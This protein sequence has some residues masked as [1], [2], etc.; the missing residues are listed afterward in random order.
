MY[1]SSIKMTA[2]EKWNIDK[3]KIECAK[4]NGYNIIVVWENDYYKDSKEFIK[5]CIKFINEN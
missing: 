2:E 3:N 1:N 5:N 4:R